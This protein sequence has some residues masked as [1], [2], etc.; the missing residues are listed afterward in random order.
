METY[1]GFV[2]KRTDPVPPIPGWEKF[3]F[4]FGR[5]DDDGRVWHA[6]TV[7]QCKHEIDEMLE[8]QP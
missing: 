4:Q 8:E 3:K 7:M 6:E 1:R 2:I 5:P